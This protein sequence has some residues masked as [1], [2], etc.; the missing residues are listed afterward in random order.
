MPASRAP[1]RSGSTCRS[2]IDPEYHYEAVNVEA[3]QNNPHSLLWWM[4]RLI[5]LR[6]QFKAFGRGTIEFL[7]PE[8]R[9]VL[10]FLRRRGRAD[11][12]RGQPLAVR[13]V[14]GARP[15]RPTREWSPSSCSG[16]PSSPHRGAAVLPHARAA[17][18]LLVLPGESRQG[19][20]DRHDCRGDPDA[21]PAGQGRSGQPVP[22]GPSR[23]AG[24]DPA[25]LPA[26][27]TLVRGEGTAHQM[28]PDPG[29]DPPRQRGVPPAP[30]ARAGRI[31]G[32]R[33]GNSIP[34]RSPSRRG[35]RRS[36]CW[37]K[38]PGR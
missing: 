17:R 18:L 3:Q 33:P 10:A 1:T 20:G 16:R 34:S 35:P 32:G 38:P 30:A 25:R 29:S 8:N 4:K 31:H 23:N 21:G 37:P 19:G 36:G 12:G 28:G 15:V 7:T 5:A 11:P 22:E 26:E 6:K 14:R 9:K 2:I 13:P 27:P 24:E